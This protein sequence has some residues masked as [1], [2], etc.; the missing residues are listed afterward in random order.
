MITKPQPGEYAIPLPGNY[1]ELINDNEDIL[2]AL[3]QQRDTSYSL[4]SSL[5]ESQANSSYAEGKWTVKEMLGH[6][7]DTERIFAYRALC[8]SR[9]QQDLPGF[10]QDVY[11]YFGTYGTR[12]IQSLAAEFKAVRDANIYLFRSIT[13]EQ[14]VRTGIASGYEVSVRAIIYATAGHERHHLNILRERYAIG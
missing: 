2:T 14:E 4:F 11:V 12:D 10:D 13:P 8:F 3:E 1:L 9:E 7:I 6:L 5:T